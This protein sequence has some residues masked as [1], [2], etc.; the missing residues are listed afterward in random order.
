MSI[1]NDERF[2]IWYGHGCLG[3]VMSSVC[4]YVC[5]C[6]HIDVCVYQSANACGALSFD[7]SAASRRESDAPEIFR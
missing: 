2:Y 1:I 4:V 7:T 5:A 6:W 3:F